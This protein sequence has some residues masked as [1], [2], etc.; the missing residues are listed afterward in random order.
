MSKDSSAEQIAANGARMTS[1]P[2]RASVP[3]GI[4]V[5]TTVAAAAASWALPD[6]YGAVAVGLI[7]IAVV[8]NRVLARESTAVIREHGLGLGGI[9]EPEPLNP[10]W[11]AKSAF[12]ALAWAAALALLTFPFFW[13]GYVFWYEPARGFSALESLR[14]APELAGQLLVVAIPE[15]CFYRGYLLSALD[16]VWPPR[17]RVAGAYVGPALVV[18]SAIFAVGHLLTEPYPGRLAVFFPALLFGW[19]RARTGGV[20][21]SIAFHA[22]CNVFAS[23][24]GYGYGLIP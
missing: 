21:A 15:E 23:A 12:E 24:L 7:F 10:R 9:F 16:R 6:D 14:M 17:F 18:T 22:L 11:I 4:G 2:K 13:L 5:G 1:E 20:G 19:L 3:L 8:H